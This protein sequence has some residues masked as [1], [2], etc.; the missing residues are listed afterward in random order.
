[1]PNHSIQAR[2]RSLGELG[3]TGLGNDSTIDLLDR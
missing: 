2:A 3:G 1:M